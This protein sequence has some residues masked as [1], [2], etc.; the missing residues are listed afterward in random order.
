MRK[1]QLYG[2]LFAVVVIIGGFVA[3]YLNNH[4]FVRNDY[5][6]QKA[7]SISTLKRDVS[8]L[9]SLAWSLQQ[10][11]DICSDNQKKYEILIAKLTD[12]RNKARNEAKVNLEA[13]EHYE[14]NGLMRFFVF[15][16]R[17]LFK[18]GCYQEVFEK[19]D[20]ICK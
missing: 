3:K 10:D 4:S 13:I 2:I 7:D 12:E 17:G 1:I 9:D 14:S 16:R 11:V 8:M 18:V 20:N 19:P 15:D 6:K 5:I